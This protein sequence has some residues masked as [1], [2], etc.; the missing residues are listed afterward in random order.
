MPDF[1]ATS[2]TSGRVRP[3]FLNPVYVS[4]FEALRDNEDSSVFEAPLR[5][6]LNHT[7]DDPI[8]LLLLGEVLRARHAFNSAEKYLRQAVTI[9]PNYFEA[10]AALARTL[11]AQARPVDANAA[12]QPILDQRPHDL[13]ASR[14]RAALLAEIGQHTEAAAIQRELLRR[15][16]AESALWIGYGDAQRT[17]GNRAD[18]E[19]AYRLG[20]SRQPHSGRLWWSLAAMRTQFDD[21]DISAMEN[22]LAATNIQ[23]ERA[24][25]HFALGVAYDRVGDAE[26]AFSHFHDGNRLQRDACPYDAGQTAADV[27]TVCRLHDHDFFARRRGGGAADPAPIFI[28]GMPRSGSTLVEQILAS[29]PLIEGTAELPIVPM[30]AMTL[31]GE[32]G[33]TTPQAYRALLGSLSR[34]ERLALGSRYLERARAWRRT[35]RPFFVDKLPY[36][37]ADIDLIHLILPNARIID[38]RRNPLDCCFSN[39]KL[40]FGQ[41]HPSAYSLSDMAHYYREYVRLMRHFEIALPDRIYRVIFE[42]LVGDIEGETRRLLD[43]IGIPFDAACL[44]FH[45][46]D[47]A[48]ATASSE[49]VRRPLNSDGI[50]AWRR[51]EPWLAPLKHALGDLQSTY[52]M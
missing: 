50:N 44:S 51:Y 46:T 41:G 36:N 6:Q 14:Y 33:R 49:Q 45:K 19:R 34:E 26:R 4:A 10:H 2:P 27:D 40:M 37:W 18:A 32:N 16:P 20:I 13:H 22:A 12:L 28:V 11:H 30:L 38:A 21:A 42:E 31:G 9:A 8:A 29:H 24:H 39:F 1:L 43:H 3:R 7:P 35:R 52:A 17:I 25:F 48:V 23:D 15:H 47:R 5:D